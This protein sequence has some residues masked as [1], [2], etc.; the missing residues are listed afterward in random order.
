M[1]PEMA[2]LDYSSASSPKNPPKKQARRQHDE[3]FD[4]VMAPAP[5]NTQHA[6]P[7]TSLD[8]VRAPVHARLS[9]E[10]APDGASTTPQATGAAQGPSPGSSRGLTPA[11]EARTNDGYPHRLPRSAPNSLPGAMGPPQVDNT[12]RGQAV[13]GASGSL[14]A[15]GRTDLGTRQP[16]EAPPYG[17]T[18]GSTAVWGTDPSQGTAQDATTRRVPLHGT[19]AAPPAATEHT[20]TQG[21]IPGADPKGPTSQVGQ[22]G[23]MAMCRPGLVREWTIHVLTYTV[24]EGLVPKVR[25]ASVQRER[26]STQ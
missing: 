13:A 5:Q 3:Q 15:G 20:H 24:M 10:N 12:G 4:A 26:T 11:K 9:T 17:H 25:W 14:P 16:D 6:D 22:L 2:D 21:W 19:S 23:L 1:R 8:E 7:C 18:G